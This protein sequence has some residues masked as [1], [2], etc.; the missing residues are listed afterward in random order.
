MEKFGLEM[1]NKINESLIK[2]NISKKKISKE[3]G[4]TQTAFSNKLKK[5]KNGKSIDTK[6]LLVIQERT[7]IIFFNI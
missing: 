1:Y 6:T 5:L 7:G 3:L 4:I 2:S